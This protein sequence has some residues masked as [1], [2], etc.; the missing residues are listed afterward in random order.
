MLDRDKVVWKLC[1]EKD[2]GKMAYMNRRKKE[3]EEERREAGERRKKINMERKE[4]IKEELTFMA[5][6][7][8]K[9]LKVF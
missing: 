1:L 4:D 9:K 3:G 6:S 2:R 7:V 8:K 5:L